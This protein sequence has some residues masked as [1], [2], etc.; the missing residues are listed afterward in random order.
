MNLENNKKLS[1]YW[2][3]KLTILDKQNFIS[4]NHFWGG[5]LAFK[6]KY[7]PEDMKKKLF[8]KMLENK[9]NL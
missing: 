4:K 6:Y 9:K 3:N 2:N 7:L 5:L 8:V 1:Y